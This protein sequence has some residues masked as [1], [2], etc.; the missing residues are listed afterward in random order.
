MQ[1]APA[2]PVEHR[3]RNGRAYHY[4][5][6][7]GGG[8]ALVGSLGGVS[9][10]LIGF[11]VGMLGVAFLVIQRIPLRIAAGTSHFVIL[12]VTGVAVAI[13][14]V[15]MQTAGITPPWNIVAV[16]AAAVLFGGQ[17]AAWLAG[18]IREDRLR[19]IL[20][21]LLVAL[22]MATL[23]RAGTPFMG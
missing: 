6:P 2:T 13:H 18:R 15:E 23:Y 9:T 4:Q 3:D 17:L 10:G 14:L 12:L 1:T 21:G 16:N 22:A 20:V 5:R 7:R 19:T 8:P 11:G